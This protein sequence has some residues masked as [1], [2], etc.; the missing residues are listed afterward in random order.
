MPSMDHKVVWIQLVVTTLSFFLAVLPVDAQEATE[1][2]RVK[3]GPWVSDLQVG[4]RMNAVGRHLKG[5][6]FVGQNLQGAVFDGCDLRDVRFH[7]CDLS[8]ASFKG[9]HMTGMLIGDCKTH[10]AD[11]TDAIING[12][13]NSRRPGVTLADIRLSEQQ[14]K[15]TH[16]YK[17]KDLS[18]CVIYGF[19]E[20]M[21]EPPRHYDF[22]GV[23]LFR[24]GLV[25]D[26]T[27]CS[28]ADASIKRT[29]MTRCIIA[30]GQLASTIEFKRRRLL[31]ASLD[32]DSIR[33]TADF[34]GMDFVETSL[35]GPFADANFDD[36]SFS[37]CR[38]AIT[39]QQLLATRNYRVGDLSNIS[40]TDMNLS[41]FDFSSVNVTSSIFWGACDFRDAIF[42][43]AVVTNVFF[44][45][46]N[47]GLTLDQVKS[48]WNYKHGRMHGITL[49][50]HIAKALEQE[51]KTE[52]ESGSTLDT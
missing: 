25:G 21:S 2:R 50:K 9:A 4:L 19:Q 16:S 42:K 17:T 18:E 5:S 47:T 44:D 51:Q 32:G 1:T 26:F 6:Q 35:S 3:L 15:S 33:G 34:S 28:F 49:P 27:K 8:G 31:G 7:Q 40:F 11:F 41:D 38:I 37:R 13:L 36:A 46:Y 24:A 39:K 23:T 10:G 20:N 52:K 45:E 14:L 12:I 30:Y 48:T 29:R 43:D 22:R